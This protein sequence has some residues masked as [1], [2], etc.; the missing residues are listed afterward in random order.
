M[1]KREYQ[2]YDE[3]LLRKLVAECSSFSEVCRKLGKKPVGGTITNLSLMCKRFGIDTTHMT[4][5][6]WNRGGRAHN[7]KTPEEFLVMGSPTDHRIAPAR[8]RK[9]LFEIGFEYKCNLCGIDSWNDQ[10][11]VLEIDHV[12]GQYWNNTK[13]NLQFLCPN[14]H[15]QKTNKPR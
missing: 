5:S 7:R 3:T 4:G 2:R 10:Q 14:C 12:D 9:H 1:T 11:L 6:C 8:M 15:S 13:E